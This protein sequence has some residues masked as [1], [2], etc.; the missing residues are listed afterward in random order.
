MKVLMF[1]WEFPP[2]ISGGLGTACAGLTCALEKEKVKILFVI[3]KLRGDEKAEH[4]TFIN[5]SSVAI[6]RNK[7]IPSAMPSIASATDNPRSGKFLT[8]SRGSQTV[9]EVPAYLSAY[10]HASRGRFGLERWNYSFTRTD[11]R[12]IPASLRRLRTFDE[13]FN[14][15][16]VRQA[17]VMEPY[18]F[19]G[20]YDNVME[21]VEHYARAGSE[22]ARQYSFDLIHA[23][24]WMTY[25]A[26]MAAKKISGKP[27][28]VHVHATEV[29]R[30][31]SHGNPDI[32]AI[33]KKGMELADKVVTV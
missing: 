30:T 27:L 33:E 20:S 13:E 22:I 17:E 1:G 3:P 18:P 12:S 7:P 31:G 2:H 28:V 14:A 5:A 15:G 24:D 25:P 11:E 16:R 21:E 10:S 8:Y 32:F 19:S 23:H 29:D 26:A 9:F 6:R 4:T